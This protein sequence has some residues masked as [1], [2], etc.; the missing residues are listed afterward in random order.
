MSK[1]QAMSHRGALVLGCW[2][3]FYMFG[4]TPSSASAFVASWLVGMNR[5]TGRDDGSPIEISSESRVLILYGVLNRA[6]SPSAYAPPPPPYFS[7]PHPPGLRRVCFLHLRRAGAS[8]PPG[9]EFGAWAD[10]VAKTSGVGMHTSL[11]TVPDVAEGV[12]RLALVSGRTS[13]NPKL[14]GD[15]IAV[16]SLTTSEIV[17]GWRWS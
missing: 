14:L 1:C 4:F 8:S 3:V 6:P 15:S 2:C 5:L 13:D 17:G 7:L 12:K 9:K 10:E 11:D 16:S